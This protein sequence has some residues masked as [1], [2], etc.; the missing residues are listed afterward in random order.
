MKRLAVPVAV[1]LLALLAF[2]VRASDRD[3]GAEEGDAESCYRLRLVELTLASGR[4]PRR[5]RFLIPPAG[6]S[7]PWPPLYH[8]SLARLARGRLARPG[9]EPALRGVDPTD[10]RRWLR[11]AS[12]LG[13]ALAV[14]LA[15]A[16]AAALVGGRAP[17]ARAAAA[18]TAAL[19]VALH[20]AAIE[21]GLAARVAPDGW[22]LALGAAVLLA[23]MGALRPSDPIDGLSFA[24]GGGLLAGLAALLSPAT[25]GA[26]LG[27]V[28][29]LLV[30]GGASDPARAADARRSGILF[31]ATA[32]VVCGI[33]RFGVAPALAEGGASSAEAALSPFFLLLAAPLILFGVLRV[34]LVARPRRRVLAGWVLAAASLG[35]V[36]A[37]AGALGALDG[38]RA[39]LE[40]W[41]PLRRP[42]PSSLA[43]GRATLVSL[44]ALPVCV[45]AAWTGLDAPRRA[46]LL[47]VAS[48][49]A[50][51]V[52]APGPGPAFLLALGV[53]FAAA[54]A[55]GAPA[56]RVVVALLLLGMLIP[57]GLSSLA[58]GEGDLRAGV[59]RGER[60]ERAARSRAR[61]DACAWLRDSTPRPAA[62]N[63][64][65]AVP[66]GAVLAPPAWDGWIAGLARRPVAASRL[67]AGAE[68]AGWSTVLG[69]SPEA[70]RSVLDE[71]R[72]QHLLLP[73]S[74][75]ACARE[76]AGHAARLLH[77]EAFAGLEH[78]WE[79]D[80]R[81]SCGGAGHGD[82]PRVSIW[83]RV[84]PRDRPAGR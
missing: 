3:H 21:L 37:L 61:A 14:L 84:A 45:A 46:L 69:S 70:L 80:E 5:D 33:A 32:G 47:V 20:P 12:P 79:S 24:L 50:G 68:D 65:Q 72:V 6:S 19:L 55:V 76:P 66:A 67:V 56:P 60:S 82:V 1:A 42:A 53:A 41:A 27:V 81:T 2:G 59:D 64:A 7:V 83:R 63:N 25:L 23:A 74:T 57:T 34:D 43:G 9:G 8:A 18:L 31:C 40:R 71:R 38:L 13:F 39:G 30:V 58:R 11:P 16:S 36:A 10:L 49:G 75:Q 51:E 29:A 17:R 54:L 28:A 26:S 62:W 22:A 78:A 48:F 35:I 73:A 77:G 15:A 4:A 44:A 52:L